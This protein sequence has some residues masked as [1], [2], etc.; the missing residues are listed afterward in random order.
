[1]VIHRINTGVHIEGG[2]I[3]LDV[4]VRDIIGN[5]ISREVILDVVRL[6]E[7][8]RLRL[9][10]KE[11]VKVLDEVEIEITKVDHPKGREVFIYYSIPKNYT[12]TI[13][14]SSE[15]YTHHHLVSLNP[16]L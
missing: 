1:M 15:L 16:N 5:Q 2:K 11:R 9:K 10:Y 8:K 13:L 7:T 3:P 12:L 14:K 4:I 6:T